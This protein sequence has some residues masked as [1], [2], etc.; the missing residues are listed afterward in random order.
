MKIS[1]IVP[2]YNAEKYITKCLDSLINQTYKDI[3]IIA[4][5]DGSTDSSYDILKSYEDK[6]TII[7]QKNHGVS[8]SRNKA[9]KKSTGDYVTFVDVDDWLDLDMIEKLYSQTEKG[10]IDIVRCGYIR[11]Y[12]NHKDPFVIT[13]K[14]IK[15][16]SNKSLIYDKFLTNYDLASP[17]GQLIKKSCIKKLFD[18]NIKVGEDYLFNLD[19]YTNATSFVLLSE[20]YYH[21]LYNDNS[22]TTSISYDKIYKRC[23]DSIVVYSQLFDY[24]KKWNYDSKKN[25]QLVNY[26]VIKELNMKL[27]SLFKN[28]DKLKNEKKKIIFE[29]FNNNN[30]KKI[31]KNL[32][33]KTIIKNVNIYSIFIIC[34][35]YNLYNLYYLFANLLYKSVYKIKNT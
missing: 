11:E 7:H 17:C 29:F 20:C 6:I 4:I 9:I 22:A 14:K 15:I 1:I 31:N 18:E 13:D 10:K 21:Y 23:E 26:R 27:I 24:I 25:I 35:K 34:I 2:I 8:Y 12:S 3:E 5:D 19:V 16:K 32:K 28:S 30:V 33:L